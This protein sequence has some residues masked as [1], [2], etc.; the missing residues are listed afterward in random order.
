MAS[1][2]SPA[3]AWYSSA[4]DSPNVSE[5]SLARLRRMAATQGIDG[6]KVFK[7]VCATPEV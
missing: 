3:G 7:A 1:R 2:Q 4:L 5:A 6:A